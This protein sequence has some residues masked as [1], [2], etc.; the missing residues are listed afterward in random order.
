MT[1]KEQDYCLSDPT[2]VLQKPVRHGHS[3]L[4][5]FHTTTC[6]K[7]IVAI[8]IIIRNITTVVAVT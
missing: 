3:K 1:L 2:K 6:D 5:S 8:A 7:D 4:Y